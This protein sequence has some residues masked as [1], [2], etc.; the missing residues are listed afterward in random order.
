MDHRTLNLLLLA[1]VV[2]RKL[3]PQSI[4][5]DSEHIKRKRR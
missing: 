3:Q 5:R 1:A 4:R 2:R